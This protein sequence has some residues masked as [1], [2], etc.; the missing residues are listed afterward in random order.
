MSV[1]VSIIR[2]RMNW[3]KSD[4]EANTHHHEQAAKKDL[5]GDSTL[6]S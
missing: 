3:C 6:Q 2:D 4:D 5:L 1:A